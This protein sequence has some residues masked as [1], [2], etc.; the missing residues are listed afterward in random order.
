MHNMMILFSLILSF[1]VT[2]KDLGRLLLIHFSPSP[3]ES[4]LLLHKMYM[5]KNWLTEKRLG[6]IFSSIFKP[7]TRPANNIHSLDSIDRVC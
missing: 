5:R 6:F 4:L 1:L 7:M 3:D 2:E